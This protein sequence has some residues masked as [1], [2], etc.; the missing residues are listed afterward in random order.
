MI[1]DM[2]S[3]KNLNQIVTELF[4]RDR[5][6]NIPLVFIKQETL[7]YLKIPKMYSLLYYENSKWKRALITI[8]HSSDIDFKEFMKIYLECTG[9]SCSFLVNNKTLTSDDPL[10]FR[11][12]LSE[13]KYNKLWKFMKILEMKNYNLVLIERLQIS[14]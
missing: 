1:V 12:D 4:I 9:E 13:R 10:R 2:I 7:K 6:R 8:N 11:K 3:N 5:K 14:A